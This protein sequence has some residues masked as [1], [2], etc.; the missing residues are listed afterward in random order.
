[1]HVPHLAGHS[2]FPAIMQQFAS[3]VYYSLNVVLLNV[4]LK[5]PELCTCSNG[6]KVQPRTAPHA[7]LG[8][9]S[10][11]FVFVSQSGR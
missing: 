6:F 10:N 11:R 1:M 4:I 7:T 9:N 3:V 2:V 8:R 5:R